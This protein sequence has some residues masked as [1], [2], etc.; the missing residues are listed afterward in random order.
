MLLCDYTIFCCEILRISYIEIIIIKKVTNTAWLASHTKWGFYFAGS[1]DVSPHQGYFVACCRCVH[2]KF[3]SFFF[4][5]L[6]VYA[7]LLLRASNMTEKVTDITAGRQ[8]MFNIYH[9][10]LW[11][12]V[13]VF[14]RIQQKVNCE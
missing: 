9:G 7:G 1:S 11:Q 3:L 5:F 8:V 2:G 4:P 6:K 13:N 14:N 12:H 10:S